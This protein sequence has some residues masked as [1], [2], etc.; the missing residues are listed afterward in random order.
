MTYEQ[1]LQRMLDSISLNVDKREG[2]LIYNALA[3]AAFELAQM[4]VEL[5][6]WLSLVF[7]HTSSGVYLDKRCNEI[8]IQRNPATKA[9]RKG[10]FNI[11]VPV[12]TRFGI[13]NITYK[14]IEIIE[15]HD[16]KL[17]CETA[18]ETGNN[19]IGALLPI[20]YVDGLTNATL[21]DVLIPGEDEETDESLLNKFNTRVKKSSTSGN[22]Y[23]YLEWTNEVDGVGAA[24]IIPLWSGQNTVKILI[25]GGDMLPASSEL[26]ADVQEYIDPSSEGIGH[27][28]APIGATCTVA[29]V[30]STS[31]DIT[32]NISGTS[33]S[34]V[35]DN[36]S[37][38]LKEY[39]KELITNDWQTKDNYVVSYAKIGS[40]LL[41]SIADAGGIDY[42]NLTINAGNSNIQLS[43]KIPV[44]GTVTL[45]DAT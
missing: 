18:G 17:E 26:I 35:V 13:D 8:G 24:R 25:V 20:D 16:Y 1:I 41:E 28:K 2:S 36:F 31:L 44:I 29:S 14:V 37:Q 42:S 11:E 19:Q 34:N 43:N 33:A 6:N 10:E 23:H 12:G 4:Y 22:I 30:E 39:F 5:E 40:L 21:T 3:P 15:N 38:K 27:G 7:A 32:A 9:I 45:N